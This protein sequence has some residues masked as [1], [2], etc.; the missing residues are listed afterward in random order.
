MFIF[1]AA[2]M[3]GGAGYADENRRLFMYLST[4]RCL[5]S[6]GTGQA[7]L[8]ELTTNSTRSGNQI[9]PSS[10]AFPKRR[11]RSTKG[12]NQLEASKKARRNGKKLCR[13]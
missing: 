5:V 11:T 6:A 2:S 13:V 10:A 9:K 4:E 3:H 1:N 8:S 7:W 12:S